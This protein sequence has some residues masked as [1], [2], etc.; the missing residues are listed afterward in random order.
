MK[1]DDKSYEAD[2][3]DP[4]G[5]EKK[6][7]GASKLSTSYN[8]INSILGSGIIGMPYALKNAGVGLGLLLFVLVSFISN[9]T[10]RLMVKNAELSGSSSYQGVMTVCFGKPG[11]III[12]IIQ[13]L[14]PY[15]AVVGYNVGVGDTL[16]K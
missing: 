8:Y 6:D 16:S 4:S 11:F 7:E 10:L 15:L 12:S 13:F 14:F 5:D 1:S 2:D 9:Y 3:N